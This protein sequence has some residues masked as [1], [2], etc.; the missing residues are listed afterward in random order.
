MGQNTCKFLKKWKNCKQAK[1]NQIHLNIQ[2]SLSQN[3][4]SCIMGQTLSKYNSRPAIFSRTP[5]NFFKS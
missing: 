5:G 4:F 3:F 1:N 2:K